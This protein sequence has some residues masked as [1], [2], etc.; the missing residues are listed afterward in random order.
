MMTPLIWL[1]PFP[2]Q[3]RAIDE[4]HRVLRPGAKFFIIHL[5]SS[6][7]LAE[8]HHEIGGAVE[9]DA[10]P[11]ATKLRKMFNSSKFA[12]VSIEDHPGLYLASAVNVK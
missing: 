2:H 5:I 1:W 6:R 10:I 4:T 3:Q 11:P 9:H 7:E 12:D 8:V